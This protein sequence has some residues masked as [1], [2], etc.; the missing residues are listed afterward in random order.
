L[1]L[2]GEIGTGNPGRALY[3]VAGAAGEFLGSSR[4]ASHDGSDLVEGHGEHIVKH[5]SE[6]FGGS[7]RIGYHQQRQ[8]DRFGHYR[9]LFRADPILGVHYR[10]SRVERATSAQHTETA[11]NILASNINHK[12][13]EVLIV[14]GSGNLITDNLNEPL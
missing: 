11:H 13:T 14:R 4:C 8:G 12:F 6:P 2:P 3:A 7:Q 9:F 5:D 10:L 1:A